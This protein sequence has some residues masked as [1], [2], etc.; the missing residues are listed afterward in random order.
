MEDTR[1]QG[2]SEKLSNPNPDSLSK[3][4]E[5]TDSNSGNS[6]KFVDNSD[7]LRKIWKRKVL[8]L[9]YGTVLAIIAAPLLLSVM[10]SWEVATLYCG[11]TSIVIG[12][13]GFCIVFIY[14]YKHYLDFNEVRIE[15]EDVTFIREPDQDVKQSHVC[16]IPF[17]EMAMIRWNRWRYDIVKVDGSVVDVP[18][19]FNDS[20]SIRKLAIAFHGYLKETT[21][22]DVPV[23]FP[24]GEIERR[25]QSQGSKGTMPIPAIGRHNSRVNVIIGF[26]FLFAVIFTLINGA[27]FFHELLWAR[28]IDAGTAGCFTASALIV[29]FLRTRFRSQFEERKI[30]R[31]VLGM[32]LPVNI[33]NGFYIV[34]ARREGFD[35]IARKMNWN[36]K[37][38]KYR[39]RYAGFEESLLTGILPILFLILFP[40]FFFFVPLSL[41]LI[42]FTIVERPSLSELQSHS[43]E[44]KSVFIIPSFI[45]LA[46]AFSRISDRISVLA[47]RDKTRIRRLLGERYWGRKG[48]TVNV[49]G[50][51][52][53]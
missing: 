26:V 28:T 20:S 44:N 30:Q 5:E 34:V 50:E 51:G 2:T 53:A 1:V 39:R 9:V 42:Y 10:F 29:I 3:L 19:G 15:G 14:S 17:S 47:A 21:G 8:L 36:H 31:R 48:E 16:L 46:I 32:E 18:H 12:S 52:G 25:T 6:V 37:L 13:I 33:R 23:F 38:D 24:S 11:L 41:E 4:P 27:E 22:E 43:I 7:P 49:E 45:I 35:E 40:L